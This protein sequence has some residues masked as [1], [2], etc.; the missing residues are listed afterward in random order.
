MHLL[1]KASTLPSRPAPQLQFGLCILGKDPELKNSKGLVTASQAPVEEGGT[2]RKG[3]PPPQG[4]W[5]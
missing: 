5:V 1:C 2:C 3:M 4:M